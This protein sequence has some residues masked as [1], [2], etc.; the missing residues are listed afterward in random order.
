MNK[1]HDIVEIEDLL[2]SGILTENY[3]HI[4]ESRTSTLISLTTS[5]KLMAL[6]DVISEF[7]KYVQK[8]KQ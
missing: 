7:L 5:P 1:T 2:Y 8:I 6:L 3:D 4:Y